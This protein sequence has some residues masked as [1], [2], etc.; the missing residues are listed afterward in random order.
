MLHLKFQVSLGHQPSGYL[1]GCLSLF[2][3]GY[4]D[5]QNAA[6]LRKAESIGATVVRFHRTRTERPWDKQFSAV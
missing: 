6:R 5:Q 3:N 4:P 2:P 1:L